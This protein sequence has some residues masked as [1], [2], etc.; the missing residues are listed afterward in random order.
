M[1]SD[2]T[3]GEPDS[4]ALT[5]LQGL[6]RSSGTFRTAVPRWD[7]TCRSSGDR[8]VEQK[9]PCSQVTGQFARI[10]RRRSKTIYFSERNLCLIPFPAAKPN[11][12][13]IDCWRAFAVSAG[14]GAGGGSGG[15]R[16]PRDAAEQPDRSPR[17]SR[18]PPSLGRIATGAAGLRYSRG[19]CKGQRRGERLG[20][21]RIRKGDT[22][23]AGTRK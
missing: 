21:R 17:Y 16:I 1:N 12:F 14:A 8:W 13:F 22:G 15:C 10:Q 2:P 23:A 18:R 3:G 20:G 6:Q 7:R 9:H 5:V 19:G 4:S 11:D